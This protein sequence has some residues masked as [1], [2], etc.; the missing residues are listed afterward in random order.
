MIPAGFIGGINLYSYVGNNPTQFIDPFGLFPSWYRF[1]Y[2]AAI[3]HR[4]LQGVASPAEIQAMSDANTEY[5]FRTQDPIYAPYHAMRRPGQSIEHARAE[6]NEFVRRKICA[7]RQFAAQG[8]MGA[9]MSAMGQANHTLQDAESPA[10]G[11]FQQAWT[12]EPFGLGN[13]PYIIPHYLRETLF[14]GRSNTT[15]AENATRQAWRYYRGE[16]MP[17]NFFPNSNDNSLQCECR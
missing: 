10:H 15:A 12:P 13:L 4:G 8:N 11:G 3:T 14:P 5:D 9:A 17:S 2:H 16:A 6:A 7:A 1:N